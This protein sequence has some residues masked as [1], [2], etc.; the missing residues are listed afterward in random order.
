MNA[1]PIPD[2]EHV[3][4]FC[5]ES[6]QVLSRQSSLVSRMA[7]PSAAISIAA[8]SVGPGPMRFATNGIRTASA[9]QLERKFRR[10]ADQWLKE[11][12][13]V[14]SITKASMHPAYQRI[15]GMGHE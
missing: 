9:Y 8:L 2:V 7:S 13:H 12:E 10:L 5:Q 1:Q 15:I 14:S 3:R 4:G 6:P 11:T